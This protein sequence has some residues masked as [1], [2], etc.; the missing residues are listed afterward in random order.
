MLNKFLQLFSIQRDDDTPPSSVV[1]TIAKAADDDDAST[2]VPSTYEPTPLETIE[3]N[4]KLLMTNKQD[5]SACS[6]V[7]TSYYVSTPPNF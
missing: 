7:T 2:V 3:Y 6:C 1:P 5:S 4:I